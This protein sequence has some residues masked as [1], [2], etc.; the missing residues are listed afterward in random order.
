VCAAADDEDKA[1][2][3]MSN[4]EQQSKLEFLGERYE[5]AAWRLA[6][7]PAETLYVLNF[8][9]SPGDVAGYRPERIEE[10]QAGEVWPRSHRSLWRSEADE[11]AVIEVQV[12]EADSRDLARAVLLQSL[13]QFQAV[14]ESDPDVGE[15]AFAT[16]G[17]GA[18]VFA[19]ANL[20]V[21]V[22]AADG[23]QRSVA[24]VSKVIEGRLRARPEE[25]GAVV[26]EIE[27]LAPGP[28]LPDGA[29]RISLEAHDPLGR[30]LWFKLFASGGE[31]VK[32][33]GELAF[34]S[35][36]PGRRELTVFAINENG[37]VARESIS[38]GEAA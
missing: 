1:N 3:D 5:F 27:R 18:V 35:Y 8:V 24:E 11:E 2:R 7:Q 9:M 20:V 36:K 26:P 31:V 19:L 33:A 28:Q 10:Q 4:H 21:L 30:P 13:G 29:F 32:E 16:R 12:L 15:V 25:G 6:G 22:R 38:L 37:G 14:L 23:P 17:R 34:R